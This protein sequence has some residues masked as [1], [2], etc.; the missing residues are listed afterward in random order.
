MCLPSFA[1][2]KKRYDDNEHEMPNIA[3]GRT[4]GAHGGVPLCQIRQFVSRLRG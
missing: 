1:A 3:C 2:K 4:T